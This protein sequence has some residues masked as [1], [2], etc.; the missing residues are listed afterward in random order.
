MLEQ[1]GFVDVHVGPG[2]DTFGGSHGEA[3]ARTFEVFGY[4]FLARRPG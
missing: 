1:A 4:P 2:W 3:N